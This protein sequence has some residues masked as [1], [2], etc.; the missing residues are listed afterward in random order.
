MLLLWGT[1]TR[2]QWDLGSWSHDRWAQALGNEN[3]KSSVKD[4]FTIESPVYILQPTQGHRAPKG[5]IP[6]VFSH[7]HSMRAAAMVHL[8]HASPC[9]MG[10]PQLYTPQS[11]GNITCTKPWHTHYA[12]SSRHEHIPMHT[13]HR[14]RQPSDSASDDTRLA[15]ESTSHWHLIST[16]PYKKVY[17]LTHKKYT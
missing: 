13:L 4:I 11:H 7:N 10:L 16:P 3:N 8:V 15:N 17:I 2:V 5:N 9:S 1:L 12:K 6:K 14:V